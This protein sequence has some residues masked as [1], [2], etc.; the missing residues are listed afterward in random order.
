MS[1]ARTVR[2]ARNPLR[3]LLLSLMV[4]AYLACSVCH[5]TIASADGAGSGAPE[6][7]TTVPVDA[8]APDNGPSAAGDGERPVCESASACHVDQ[9]AAD[10]KILALLALAGTLAVLFQAA[11][12][13]P[14]LWHRPRTGT[15]VLGGT[16]LL[17]SLCVRR[18]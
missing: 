9:R 4:L 5:A 10:S 1:H 2:D 13:R 7:A 6:A 8:A 17:T 16:R 11:P 14:R 18:V 15:A 12:P 3:V